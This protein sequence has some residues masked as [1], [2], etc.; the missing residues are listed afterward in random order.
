MFKKIRSIATVNVS[1]HVEKAR[2]YPP[3]NVSVST[4]IHALDNLVIHTDGVWTPAALAAPL[5]VRTLAMPSSPILPPPWQLTVP[6]KRW[7]MKLTGPP[8]IKRMTGPTTMPLTKTTAKC[9][10]WR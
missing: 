10:G 2:S 9:L 6:Y 8:M 5:K 4:P 1:S 7:R 3:P